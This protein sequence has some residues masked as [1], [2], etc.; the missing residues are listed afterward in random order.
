M[1]NLLRTLVYDNQVSVTIADTTEMVQKGMELHHLARGSAYVFG[2]ALSLMTFMSACLKEEKG[3][4]SLSLKGDA[5][6]EIAV[7]GNRQLAM[8]GYILAQNVEEETPS[9]H[10]LAETLI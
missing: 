8:R 3:E 4:I 1:K 7:S 2:K 10:C 9:K 6:G 5:V